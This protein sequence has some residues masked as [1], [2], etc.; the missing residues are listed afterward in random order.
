MRR[1]TLITISTA[2]VLGSGLLLADR[3]AH[4]CG[5]HLNG[6]MPAAFDSLAVQRELLLFGC[7]FV[8]AVGLKLALHYARWKERRSFTWAVLGGLLTLIALASLARPNPIELSGIYWMAAG[9]TAGILTCEWI[10]MARNQASPARAGRV[11]GQA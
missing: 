4:L 2:L 10:S 7:P 9:M 11:R 8:A 3:V 6:M 1:R 5:G